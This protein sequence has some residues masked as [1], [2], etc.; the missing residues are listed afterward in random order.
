MSLALILAHHDRDGIIDDHVVA[1]LRAYRPVVD[2]LVM[3]STSVPALPEAAARLVDRFISRPNEGYDFC[4]W[5]LGIE[6][7]G[8]P[9]VF[10][11]L[12]C[13]NDSVYGPLF[14]PTAAI[15]HP[16]LATADFGGM[17]LSIQDPSGGGSPRPHVQSW[18]LVFQRSVLESTAFRDFWGGVVPLGRKRDIVERYELG[19]S[20]TLTRSGFRMAAVYD[21]REHGPSTRAEI[22]PHLSW[23]EPAR[24][25]RHLRKSRRAMHNPSELHWRRLIEAGVPFAKVSLFAA[26]HYGLDTTNVLRGIADLTPYDRGLI[27]RHL[28]RITA[29]GSRR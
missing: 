1:A 6:S 9:A 3:V 28:A 13:V 20:E 4:S 11:Q 24:S 19:L 29:P 5:R 27:E 17:C 25:L 14:D 8:R 10:D 2:E 21:G 12:I 18:F 15:A 16:T 26:N 22:L 7:L 23:R